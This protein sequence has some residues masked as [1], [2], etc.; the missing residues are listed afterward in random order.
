MGS[1][2]DIVSRS[3]TPVSLLAGKFQ[4]VIVPPAHLPSNNKAPIIATAIAGV[5]R[6]PVSND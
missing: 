3:A 1:A 6:Q 2:V 5:R 4:S